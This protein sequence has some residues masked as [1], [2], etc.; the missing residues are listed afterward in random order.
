MF[1]EFLRFIRVTIKQS[2]EGFL[3][4]L[5][6]LCPI[7][8][9]L[10]IWVNSN[11]LERSDDHG[12][13]STMGVQRSWLSTDNESPTIMKVRRSWL[14]TDSEIPTIMK[15]W[16]SWLS[17]DN[18]YWPLLPILLMIILINREI[19]QQYRTSAYLNWRTFRWRTFV[20]WCSNGNPRLVHTLQF[21][22]LIL[23]I[24][25]YI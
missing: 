2:M 24:Y 14:S 17:T 1:R 11:D 8:Y 19:G 23:L 25:F 20:I 22:Y 21:I 16:R 4:G 3:T 13:P 7:L 15:V 5:I 18:D 10:Y 9:G 6:L 12:C